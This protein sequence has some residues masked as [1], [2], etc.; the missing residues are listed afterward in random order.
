VC[1]RAG[2]GDNIIPQ[3]IRGMKARGGGFHPCRQAQD[4]Q[5]YFVDHGVK[6]PNASKAAVLQHGSVLD[7]TPTGFTIDGPNRHCV[8]LH[9]R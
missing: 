7:M 3:S 4:V 8:D 9:H 6:D 1:L 2:D 5:A